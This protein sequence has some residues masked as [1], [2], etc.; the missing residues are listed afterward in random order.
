MAT[1]PKFDDQAILAARP[2][3]SVVSVWEPYHFLVENERSDSGTVAPTATLFLTNRECPFHCLMC[4]LWKNTL[5]ERV[6]V[7]AI[8]AQ[9]DFALE[10]LP[11]AQHIKLYNSGNFFDAQ[12]IPPEDHPAIA[13]R[14]RDFATVVVENH[15]RLCGEKCGE[16][17]ERIPG[18]LEVAL[19]LETIHPNVLSRLNKRMTVE[20]YNRAV[21]GLLSR[22]IAVRT[23]IL[24]KPPFLDIREGEE[25][26]LRSLEHAFACG[27]RVCSIIPTR[28]GNGI[29]EQLS[30]DGLFSPPPLE[31]LETVFE[32]ALPWDQGRLFVDLWDVER[33]ANCRACASARVARLNQM[34]LTQKILPAIE[35]SE[36]GASR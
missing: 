16:F 34:N 30:K 27:S 14:L 32:T 10:R 13:W 31:S 1:L 8:P 3:R 4:D 2:E 23:F 12:A 17:A 29:M 6:P 28:G 21:D 19:G 15:P 9:I 11:P 5:G 25:W 18:Q 20:D 22:Q 24:L 7:G 26:C 35:C 36:C 33:F